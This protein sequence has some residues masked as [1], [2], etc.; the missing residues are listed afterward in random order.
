MKYGAGNKFEKKRG[1]KRRENLESYY[2]IS[3]KFNTDNT[4]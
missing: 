4:F 3:A 2:N 1:K